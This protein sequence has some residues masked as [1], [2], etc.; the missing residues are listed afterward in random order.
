[1]INLV[2]YQDDAVAKLVRGFKELITA[3][4]PGA[5]MVLKSPTGSGK[6]VMTASMLDRLLYEDLP[7]DF[8]FIWASVGDLAHQ[9]Y[10]KLKYN[11]L[12]DSRFT[13]EELEELQSAA[14]EKDTVLFCNW[15]K[16][17]R[18]SKE[19]DDNGEEIEVFAN[20]YVRIGED[21]RNLQE[22][23]EKTR[24]LR[25]KII[26]I[27]DEAHRTYLGPNSQRLVKEVIRPD[28]VIEVSATPS[29]KLPSGYYEKNLGRYIEVPLRQVIESGLI[30]NNTVINNDIAGVVSK[31]SADTVVLAAALKQRALLAEKYR[32]QG[33]N[34]NPLILVQLPNEKEKM[35]EVDW[36]TRKVVEK[37]MNENGIS[38]DNGKL[39]IWISGEHYP[40]DVRTSITKNDSPIEVL[41]FKQAIA[42]GWDC[43]RA[44]ILV[45]LRDIK[46]VTFEIQTVG[47]ILRMPELHHYDDSDL[48]SAY[49]FTNIN[50]IAFRSDEDTQTFFKTNSSKRIP[51]F[52][53]F[54]VFPNIY[55]KRVV[56]QRNR[57][58]QNFRPILLPLLDN[59]FKIKPN[60][61]K[62]ERL[63]KIDALLEI[64]PDELTI[65]ILSD[66]NFQHLD[67][68][69]K[70]IFEDSQ[71][72]N[73]EADKPYIERVFNLFLK[74]AS[75]PYAPHDSSRILKDAIYKWFSD[76]G[77]D[78]ESEVQ[79]IIACSQPNQ[80]IL[81]SIIDDAKKEFAKTMTEETQLTYTTFSIPKEQEFGEI[82][83]NFPSP[84]HVL[85]P[86]YRPK[87]MWNT[88]KKFEALLDNSKNVEWWYKN[89][90]SEPKYFGVP[91][92]KNDAI[93]LKQSIFY[94]DYIVKFVDRT[95]GVF[96]TKSGSSAKPGEM[97]GGSVDEKANGLQ[98]FFH[99][100]DEIAKLYREA[101]EK[102]KITDVKG[103]WGGIVNMAADGH[104]ELQG[105]AVTHEMALMHLR[106]EDVV[107][108]EVN[109]DINNW[110]RLI[111]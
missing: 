4:N 8:V 49:V 14:L 56:G 15:E 80:Q 64:Y 17:F 76:N 33:A 100:Y 62:K 53:D 82:Y 29:T 96:D 2:E 41:I 63:K 108:P 27:V 69:D 95:I 94:P 77:I 11:Y 46:S 39:A 13:F 105:D 101:D 89:G 88:E 28:L 103:L 111:I 85:Q 48:N 5:T 97:M 65:P 12:T 59:R 73:L 16:M 38:Y 47:R 6:T 30:K 43:P 84:K 23:L 81:N 74:S 44:S 20:V 92:Y 93:G 31:K 60:E 36:T 51:E 66:V 9:S 86:Y 71:R 34:I 21:G 61:S 55:R 40:E 72:V 58:N 78:D 26:L 45:M 75:S 91:Y 102:F 67:T 79:R 52:K 24:R 19:I 37:F 87:Q 35:N 50:D 57:L 90:T 10:L 110:N 83:E 32:E 98:A 42:T 104:F 1:M 22:V 109:Y 68:V 107:F 54:F 7:D 3:N 25:R 99:D 18:R 70:E 106:G